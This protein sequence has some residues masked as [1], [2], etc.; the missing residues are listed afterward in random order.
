METC[1]PLTL[2]LAAAAVAIPLGLACLVMRR[3]TR[4]VLREFDARDRAF[5]QRG[6]AR[7]AWQ[8]RDEIE[9]GRLSAR[10]GTSAPASSGGGRDPVRGPAPSRAAEEDTP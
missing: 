9:A 1:T 7:E 6:P 2:V 5:A 3:D 4:R 8:I 10:S